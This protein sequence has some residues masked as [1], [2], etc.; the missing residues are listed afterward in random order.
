MPSFIVG[1]DDPTSMLWVQVHPDINYSWYRVFVRLTSDPNSSV[2]DRWYNATSAFYADVTG[3]APGTSYT[4]NVAYN[5][6]PSAVGS[7]W[8]GSQTFVTTGGAAGYSATLVFDANG[9][10]G[11]PGSVSGQGDNQYVPITVPYAQPTR[12]GYT[13]LGWSLDQG[14]TAASYY[15]GGTYG[16]Y[17]T[18][19]GYTHTLYAV[20]AKSGGGAY[21]WNGY[22]MQEAA[23]YINRY[24]FERSAPY[25]YSYGWKKGQ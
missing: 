12:Q 7:A 20:W 3:L 25:I 21:V 1:S 15:P 24:G 23:V 10:Y 16:W 8:I 22:G 2:F 18:T 11:A 14:A 5:T 4:I 13:F 9:G 17:G 19:Y 6:T